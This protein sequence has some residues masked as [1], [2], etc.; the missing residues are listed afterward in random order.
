[1]SSAGSRCAYPVHTLDLLRDVPVRKCVVHVLQEGPS[2]PILG[3]SPWDQLAQ[4]LQSGVTA[5]PHLGMQVSVR[6]YRSCGG[7]S[8][9]HADQGAGPQAVLAG[10]GTS[11]LAA[12]TSANESAPNP[13][14]SSPSG[15]ATACC[16]PSSAAASTGIR[17]AAVASAGSC[18]AVA[19]L[20]R[21]ASCNASEGFGFRDSLFLALF[22]AFPCCVFGGLMAKAVCLGIQTSLAP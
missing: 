21:A 9:T 11:S 12:T 4:G 1:M 13:V 16:Q 6:A 20:P 7:N 8:P 2:L 18:S 3:A 22:W 10:S 15:D 17:R 14:A 19:V 5:A